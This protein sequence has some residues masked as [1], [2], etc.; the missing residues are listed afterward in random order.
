MIYQMPVCPPIIAQ[1]Q[2]PSIL[3]SV[4]TDPN[5]VREY[6]GLKAF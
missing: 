4:S 2:S 3:D 1:K 6:M 5:T